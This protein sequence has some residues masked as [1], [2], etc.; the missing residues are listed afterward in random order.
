M[1]RA[2]RV[3][4]RQILLFKLLRLNLLKLVIP[5]TLL[6]FSL[7]FRDDSALQYVVAYPLV[8]LQRSL[9]LDKSTNFLML[10]E[11]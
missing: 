11:M 4:F 8:Y 5:L 7:Y 9:D 6:S 1:S 10:S 3:Q 2:V